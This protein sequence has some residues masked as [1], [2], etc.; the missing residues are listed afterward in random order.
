MARTS[1]A[2]VMSLPDAAQTWNF[3]L[4]I[5][6]IPGGISGRDLTI[7]CKSSAIP[8][9]SIEPIPIELHGVKKQEGGRAT[10]QHTFTAMFLETVDYKT[11]SDFRRWRDL[12]RSWK[13]NKGALS[14]EYK[15]NL[16][17]DLYDNA[18]NITNTQ[19]IV[20]AWP[21]D[22]Q[23]VQLNGAESQ[24]VEISITFSFDYIDDGV[25]F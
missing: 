6:N 19:M 14:S 13:R 4:F 20:G 21:Q 22:I 17:I 18:G 23:E 3:D 25:S 15:V 24:A 1:H 10:Y 5:P 16:E 9:S 7:K 12:I 8:G 11:M 2:D